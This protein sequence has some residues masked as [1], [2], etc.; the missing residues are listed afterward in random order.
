M[1]WKSEIARRV[2]ALPP[3][4]QQQVYRYVSGLQGAQP[5]GEPG[6]AWAEWAGALDAESAR[7]MIAAIEAECERVDAGDW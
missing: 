6:T 4:E 5:P 3:E 7:E 1:D 2:E